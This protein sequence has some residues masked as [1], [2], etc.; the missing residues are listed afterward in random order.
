MNRKYVFVILLFTLVLTVL[1]VLAE[2]ESEDIL[3]FSGS[4]M[5][6]RVYENASSSAPVELEPGSAASLYAEKSNI[7]TFVTENHT[8]IVTTSEAGESHTQTY[9]WEEKADKFILH[10]DGLDLEFSCD[11]ETGELHRYWVENAADS[12]Y[13]DLDFVYTRVPICSWMLEAVYSAADEEKPALLEPDAAAS[14]YAEKENVYSLFEDGSASVLVNTSEGGE[15]LLVDEKHGRWEKEG[16]K[17]HFEVEGF[18]ME[19]SFDTKENRL[20]RY[21]TDASEDAMYPSL[22]FVYSPQ[23]N[24]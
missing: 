3:N 20:H 15:T 2:A 12:M 4:W 10:E 14:L 5:L 11:K 23:E 1:P 19:F 7:Y 22:D 18:E 8:V 21:L 16:N 6:D 9:T 17:Y 13:H 24:R